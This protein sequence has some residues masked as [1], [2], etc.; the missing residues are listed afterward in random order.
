[1]N[2]QPYA[3]LIL[4]S[5]ELDPQEITGQ[6]GVNPSSSFKKGDLR[7]EGKVWP[8]GFWELNSSEYVKSDDISVHI[9]WI[10][11]KIYPSETKLISILDKLGIEGE[12]SCFWVPDGNHAV[13]NLNRDLLSKIASLGVNLEFDL[14]FEE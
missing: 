9:E 5:K 10:M 8:H 4:R 13:V 11:D 14:Y 3:S 6:I 7:R 2:N 12:I 1:M